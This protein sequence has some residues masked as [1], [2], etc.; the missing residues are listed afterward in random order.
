MYC[1]DT[2]ISACTLDENQP[3]CHRENDDTG[4]DARQSLFL[5]K[6][7]AVLHDTHWTFIGRLDGR[8]LFEPFME[9][10]SKESIPAVMFGVGKGSGAGMMIFM[11]GLLGMVICLVFGGLLRRYRYKESA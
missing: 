1:A 7:A 10:I 11:L 3:G 2:R 6:H 5:Q 4:R 8:C 9:S